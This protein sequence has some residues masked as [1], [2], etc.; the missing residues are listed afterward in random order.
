MAA[1][2][3]A[4]PPIA[5]QMIKQSTNQ[6]SNALNHAIMHMDVDQNMF[7]AGTDDRHKAVTAYQQGEVGEF[8][9]N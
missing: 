7:A 2:Y 9:G 1:H 6:I 3:A 8:T 4:K 5:V